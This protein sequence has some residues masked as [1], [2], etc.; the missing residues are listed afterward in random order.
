QAAAQH[1][2]SPTKAV[3]ASPQTPGMYS[4]LLLLL[5]L[6]ALTTSFSCN[7]LRHQDASFSWKSLQ[8]L[9]DM[10]PPPPHPCPQ[11]DATFP[12]PETL[13][14]SKDKKQA[15]ITTL[16][17]LQDLFNMLSSPN[18]PT[19]WS[20][21]ARHSLLNHIQHYIHHLEQ[22]L[23]AQGTHSQRRGPRNS[24]LSIKKYFRRIHSFL[25]HNSYSACTWDH[26]RL[27]ARDCF[28]RVDTL[29]RQM[30]SRAPLTASSKTLST[31]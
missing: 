1:N 7:H 20:D 16:N 24:H 15:A 5:L 30:R 27:Q 2:T 18:T 12:F 23:A 9:Q 21:Q 29:I 11:Q 19:H 6:P 26:V 4:I 8:I 3:P 10:A 28:Q 14:E 22:C 25:Q 17:I 31:Q 13:L